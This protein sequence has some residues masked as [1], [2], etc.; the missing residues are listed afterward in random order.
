M[1]KFNIDSIKGLDRVE[2]IKNNTD[3]EK[4]VRVG[5]GLLSDVSKSVIKMEIINV[6]REQ[7]VKNPKNKYS[8]KGIDTLAQSIKDYG[9]LQPLHVSK[10]ADGRYMLLGG[11][12]RLTAIDKLIADNQVDEWN[13]DTLIPCVDK[14]TD[15]INLP[16]SK[17]NKERYAIITTNK[18]ARKYT[19]ADAYMEIT[20]WKM[21]IEELRANGVEAI[22]GYDDEGKETEIKIQGEKTRD[23]LTQTTGISRG[24]I[25]KFEKVDKNATDEIKNALFNNNLTVG[26]AAKAVDELNEDEQKKLAKASKK[27][28]IKSSDIK[29]F[30]EEKAE[31]LTVDAEVFDRDIQKITDRISEDNIELKDNEIKKYYSLIKQ[32]EKL[33]G[34]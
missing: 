17:D 19:D 9:L 21:I 27:K 28:Q 20:E 14:P 18:E 13:E 2:K 31:T 33:L 3:D 16:L 10:Q 1:G 8:I 32:L 25:N 23:I 11:E 12:R 6:P 4:T 26:V 15:S 29:E 5:A 30:K 7:L 34:I 22:T 24:Q